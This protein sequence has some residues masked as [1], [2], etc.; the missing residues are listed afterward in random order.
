MLQDRESLMELVAMASNS[1]RI[2]P[3]P[4]PIVEVVGA[5]ARQALKIL[6]SPEPAAYLACPISSLAMKWEYVK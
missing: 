6:L 3:L 4:N 5:M 1:S 2:L